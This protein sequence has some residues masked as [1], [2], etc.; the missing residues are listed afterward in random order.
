MADQDLRATASECDPLK[1]QIAALEAKAARL[2]EKE[3]K[4][5]VG[6][7]R[8]LM[9]QLGV[10]ATDISLA[11]GR[12]Q[13]QSSGGRGQVGSGE[14]AMR[15]LATVRQAQDLASLAILAAS[16]Q[17]VTL[18]QVATIRDGTADPTQAALLDGRPVVGFRVYRALGEGEVS[19]DDGVK[20]ALAALA[21]KKPGLVITQVSN[22]VDY[23]REEYQ[24]SMDISM[25][26]PYWPYW[27]FGGS[28]GTGV[29]PWL[30]H[31]RC[32][33][34]SSRCSPR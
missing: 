30:Q 27:P 11:L 26:A 25:K 28:C 18:D 3:T 22:N 1:K 6:R 33:S 7:V 4:V 29:P 12:T 9:N 34:Q 2:A 21:A 5:S 8:A 31:L 32:H 10:T 19:L 23:T 14:Q 16:G 24:G 20:A 17:R 13:Q 15:V